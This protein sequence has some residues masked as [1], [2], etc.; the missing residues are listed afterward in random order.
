VLSGRRRGREKWQVLLTNGVLVP[1][2]AC[3]TAVLKLLAN[4]ELTQS[5]YDNGSMRNG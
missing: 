3:L 1:S 2:D 5:A 4:T